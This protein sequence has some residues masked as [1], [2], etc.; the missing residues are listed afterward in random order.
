MGS[1]AARPGLICD[2]WLLSDR[3]PDTR[4]F[5][6]MAAGVFELFGAETEEQK[7]IAVH[8]WVSISM[9]CSR[10]IL[11]GPSG[12][13]AYNTEPGRMFHVHG[14]HTC[15][16]FARIL[17]NIWQAT[18][19]PARKIVMRQL[20]HCVGELWY[21]DRDGVG[22]WHAFDAEWGWYVYDRSGTYIASFADIAADPTLMTHPRKTSQPFFI[23]ADHRENNLADMHRLTHGWLSSITP[24]CEYYP[25]VNLAPGQQWEI[26]Y[27]PEGPACP[28]CGDGSGHSTWDRRNNYHE[29][30]SVRRPRIWPWRGQYLREAE[31][32]KSRQPVASMPHGTARLTWEVPLDPAVLTGAVGA[33]VI[34]QVSYDAAAGELRPGS[35]RELAQVILPI[36]LPYLITRMQVQ[37]DIRRSGDETNHIALHGSLDRQNWQGLGGDY[38]SVPSSD[39]TA[40]PG[41]LNVDITP[42]TYG[43]KRWTPIGA[44]QVYLRID[45]ASTEDIDAVGLKGLKFVID[46]ETN[47]FAHCHLQPGPNL[48]RLA[49]TGR[50]GSASVDVALDWQEADQGRS[51][52]RSGI[53]EGD[54]W[55]IETHVKDPGQI[56]MQ[57]MVYRYGQLRGVETAA[58][59]K[60]HLHPAP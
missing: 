36:R 11:E 42:D 31:G 54:T 22:R 57:R 9:R 37:A 14:H 51:A 47:L 34:G 59:A 45:L 26:F 28:A 52:E 40:G 5:A 60:P 53:H 25:H 58:Q 7:A 17:V 30:G 44:Y 50:Q 38:C 21:V 55:R 1:L 29:D 56:R 10:P 8:D 35:S 19:R 33:E 49:G 27:S 32:P 20:T 48:L 16:G 3:W 4:T 43:T 39:K 6:S 23:Y 15:D 2:T 24:E 18:G 12:A 46:T 41:L 13:T